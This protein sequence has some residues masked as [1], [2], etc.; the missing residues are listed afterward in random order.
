ML[1]KK[2][3]NQTLK[4]YI[5]TLKKYLFG[6]SVLAEFLVWFGNSVHKSNRDSPVL[7]IF[8]QRS[9]KIDCLGLKKLKSYI[10]F[11]CFIVLLFC[12]ILVFVFGI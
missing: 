1:L 12:Y 10:F 11:L 5:L 2:F 6:N 9:T 8:T 7:K 4:F 3:K